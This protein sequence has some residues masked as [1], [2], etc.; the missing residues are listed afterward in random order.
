MHEDVEQTTEQPL[1]DVAHSPHQ[2]HF[3]E[4]PLPEHLRGQQVAHPDRSPSRAADG[5][6]LNTPPD[7][8]HHDG[9]VQNTPN[10]A[11]TDY[12][13]SDCTL[14]LTVVARTRHS[15]RHDRGQ[16][17]SGGVASHDAFVHVS[18]LK[19]YSCVVLDL[20]CLLRERILLYL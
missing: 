8:S 6:R 19:K 12:R 1:S 18:L 11:T 13:G 20:T 4:L 10:Q 5:P 16:L 3:A 9:G 7:R 17:P 14:S 2:Q 15:L